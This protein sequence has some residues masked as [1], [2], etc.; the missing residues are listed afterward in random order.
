[1]KVCTG[2]LQ[3][4]IR[5]YVPRCMI[6]RRMI[7][8]FWI[9]PWSLRSKLLSGVI[10]SSILLN[11]VIFISQMHYSVRSRISKKYNEILFFFL[12]YFLKNKKRKEFKF[13]HRDSLF[14][15]KITVQA[16]RK[17]RFCNLHEF[18]LCEN[19]DMYF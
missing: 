10:L 13:T 12:H 4:Y 1:M 3:E 16:V 14:S 11:L 5:L 17:S 19:L 6:M 8:G 9:R 15:W 7:H 18:L 2:N